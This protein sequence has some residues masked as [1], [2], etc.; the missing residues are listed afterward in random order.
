MHILIVASWYKN[1]E[2]PI[3]GSF[4]EEQARMLQRRGHTVAVLHVYINGTFRDTLSGRKE[5]FTQENDNGIVTM[6]LATNVYV[7][8]IRSLSYSRLCRKAL[9]CVRN[10]IRGN[11]KIDVIHSHAMFMGGVVAN[12]ISRKLN[13]PYFHTE[14]TSGFIFRPEQ[15]TCNDIQLAKKVYEQSRQ[16]FFV[17]HFAKEQ[18]IKLCGVD[19]KKCSVLHNVVSPLFFE[20]DDSQK[21]DHFTFLA[22][23]NFIPLKN[24]DKI[25]EAWSSYVRNQ[26][27]DKLIIV[28]DGPLKLNIESSI[29]TLN[30][31]DS[32]KMLP[33]QSREATALLMHKSH[34]VLS[35]S[36]I[37]TFGMTLAE[38]LAS[39]IPVISTNS[40]GVTDIVNPSNGILLDSISTKAIEKGMSEMREKYS[41]FKPVELRNYANER[42]SEEAIFSQLIKWYDSL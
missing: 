31:T 14:H 4:I 28:G 12:Y 16:S 34:V 5:L 2:N 3:A 17:S 32:V 41:S 22:I 42:F 7:P 29:K 33:R 39:G 1:A 9:K 24:F 15:Y 40:G 37:E 36:S 10:Y 35:A 21:F 25:I 26:Q 27:S 11:G 30:L 23:G 6:R 20:E 38:A 8:K 19:E 13:I 18:I